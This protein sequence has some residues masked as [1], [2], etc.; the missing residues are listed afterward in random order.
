M[1][2]RSLRKNITNFDIVHLHS[3]FLWPTWAAARAAR[4]HGIPYVLSPRG[5]LVKNL[6]ARK[7]RLLKTGWIRLIEQK[8]IEQAAAIHVTSTAEAAALE[9]FAFDLPPV[10]TL[11]NGVDPPSEWKTEQLSSDVRSVIGR[12]GYVLFLGRLNWKKGLDRLLRTWKDVPGERLVIAGNDE[13]EY[14]PELER[15]TRAEGI[16]E[17]VVFLARSITGADKEALFAS[18]RLFVLPSYSENFGITVLEAMLRG[19]PVAVTPEVGAAEIVRESGAGK[20]FKGQSI[21]SVLTAM[22]HNEQLLAAMS[23]KGHC[24]ASRF[25]GWQSIGA[26]MERLYCGV[27]NA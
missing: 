4:N 24:H 20:V 1:M 22:L 6:I 3:V 21:G 14:L 11:A 12:D 23:G 19:V 9:E 10:I 26:A 8:N 5:M 15:I 27:G 2:A 17:R 13:E 16:R 7:S 18:A 25:F